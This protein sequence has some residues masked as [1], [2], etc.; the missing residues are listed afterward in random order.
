MV[1]CLSIAWATA[2]LV[3]TPSADVASNGRSYFLR[4]LASKSPANPPMPPI[5][6]GRLAFSTQTFISSTA[7]SPAS[8]ETPEAAY[9]SVTRAPGIRGC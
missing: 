4:A 5:T 7:L 6:S 3:P 1:S 8:M 9:A 2:T